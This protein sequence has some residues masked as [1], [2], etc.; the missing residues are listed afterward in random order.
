MSETPSATATS[1]QTLCDFSPGARVVI[2]DVVDYEHPAS[3]RLL[4]LGFLPGTEVLVVR[5]APLRD[6]VIFELRGNRMALRQAEASRVLVHA[7]E[8][9]EA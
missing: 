7:A 6:P 8:R 9:G 1:T 3:K 4:D 2:D 5:R